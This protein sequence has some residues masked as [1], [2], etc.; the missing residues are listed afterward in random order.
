MILNWTEISQIHRVEFYPFYFQ[1]ELDVCVLVF[2]IEEQEA[3]TK[4]T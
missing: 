4:S 3:T 1:I 2:L